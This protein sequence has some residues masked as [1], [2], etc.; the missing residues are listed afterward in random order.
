MS[1][2]DKMLHS[3][4]Y[5]NQDENEYSVTYDNS[6]QVGN[7]DYKLINFDKKNKAFYVQEE[8]DPKDIT[9]QEYKAIHEK[10]KELG[11]LDE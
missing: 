6:N 4:G 11:W 10:L 3:L 5:T 8:Y 7:E 2:A 9:M 1:K